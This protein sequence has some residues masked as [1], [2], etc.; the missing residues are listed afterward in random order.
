M[1]TTVLSHIAIDDKGVAR[2]DGT[3]FKV[4]HLIEAWKG[5][6]STPGALREAYPHLTMGQ[7][8]A[9][10]AYYYDH[11]REIDAQIDRE[12]KEANALMTQFGETPG[13]QKLRD[14]GLRR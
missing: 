4:I 13:R 5:G 7:I 14:L 11:S 12:L 8:H 2:I 10:L 9:C 3:R 6:A 1:S